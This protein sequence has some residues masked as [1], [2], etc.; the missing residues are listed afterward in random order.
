MEIRP[1]QVRKRQPSL[2]ETQR[3][4]MSW[5]NLDE[6][7]RRKVRKLLVELM[8]SFVSAKAA[9]ASGIGCRDE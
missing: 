8:S 7:T 9:E 4:H 2:F 6:E 5:E 3:S 1:T